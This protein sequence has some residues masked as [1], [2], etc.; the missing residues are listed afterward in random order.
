M[1][2]GSIQKGIRLVQECI[3]DGI[4]LNIRAVVDELAHSDVPSQHGHPSEVIAVPVRGD[5]MIDL[6]KA[7]IVDRSQDSTRVT[8][9]AGAHVPCINQKRLAGRGHHQHRLATF[10]IHHVDLQAVWRRQHRRQE[11]ED[12]ETHRQTPGG[13]P[14]YAA[15]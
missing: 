3:D 12:T 11:E 7:R 13:V 8:V 14:D 15:L 10:D 2:R 4:G 1:F 6:L 9:T 5:E